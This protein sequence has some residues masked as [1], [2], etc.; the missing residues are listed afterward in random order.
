MDIKEA[1]WVFD[2]AYQVMK[3][4]EKRA[5]DVIRKKLAEAEKPS[6]NSDYTAAL[7]KAIGDF[8]GMFDNKCLHENN[9]DKL[10]T[11]LNSVV[12]SQQDSA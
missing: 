12:K 5:W 10:A 8:F 6:H 4:D 2:T 7:R 1:V 11:R 3:P 9:M